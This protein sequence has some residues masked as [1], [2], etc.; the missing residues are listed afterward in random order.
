MGISGSSMLSWDTVLLAIDFATVAFFASIIHTLE[1]RLYVLIPMSLK[2]GLYFFVA[3]VAMATLFQPQDA[4]RS[5]RKSSFVIMIASLFRMGEAV[6]TMYFPFLE[7]DWVII[8]QFPFALLFWILFFTSREYFEDEIARPDTKNFTAPKPSMNREMQPLITQDNRKGEKSIGLTQTEVLC[9]AVQTGAGVVIAGMI[10][11]KDDWW[12]ESIF[13]RPVIWIQLV[14]CASYVIIKIVQMRLLALRGVFFSTVHSDG[15]AWS[16]LLF[17]TLARV[18]LDAYFQIQSNNLKNYFEVSNFINFGKEVVTQIIPHTFHLFNIRQST[19]FSKDSTKS[20]VC[21]AAARSKLCFYLAIT[22][23]HLVAVGYTLELDAS[24]SLVLAAA[25]AAGLLS[26]L[27]LCFVAMGFMAPIFSF[28][29]HLFSF[30]IVRQSSR[31]I[32]FHRNVSY[33]AVVFFLLH[34]VLHVIY[35]STCYDNTKCR[36]N[37]GIPNGLYSFHNTPFLTGV[38]MLG[39]F[40]GALLTGIMAARGKASYLTLAL[41]LPLSC[42]G[43]V[44]LFLHGNDNLLR[45]HDGSVLSLSVF[46]ASIGMILLYFVSVRI[47]TLDLATVEQSDEYILLV[48]KYNDSQYIIPGS[49]FNIYATPPSYISLFHSHS[50]PVFSTSD[51]QIAFLIRKNSD[52]KSFT[53]NLMLGNPKSFRVQGPFKG[54]ARS[55]IHAIT[56]KNFR[57]CIFMVGWQAGFAN[58]FSLLEYF[59]NAKQKRLNVDSINCMFLRINDDTIRTTIHTYIQNLTDD[60]PWDTPLSI[61][62]ATSEDQLQIM[63]NLDNHIR[64]HQNGLSEAKLR[65]F[66]PDNEIWFSVKNDDLPQ[67]EDSES[68]HTESREIL[69]APHQDSHFPASPPSFSFSS[70][71]APS[72]NVLPSPPTAKRNDCTQVEKWI[73]FCGN[74]FPYEKY[75]EPKWYPYVESM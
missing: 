42:A 25:H 67:N 40:I 63:T 5:F 45:R 75:K 44:A 65:E 22:T 1:P 24:H 19:K 52:T 62:E 50:F 73:Y 48:L 17:G 30:G 36:K 13:Y 37:H 68:L 72:P 3:L 12:E 66:F 70:S 14:C 10:C 46:V 34:V 4:T 6:V 69:G 21:D 15:F 57:K 11:W 64:W 38:I 53:S 55:F 29:V 27:D 28:L 9:L 71:L 41:H 59:K 31:K 2:L 39:C 26:S 32:H 7:N 61:I 74:N 33:S 8:T 20:Y 56:S 51:S 49:F 47:R 54:P 16:L 43:F 35:W 58:V 23:L 60:W 18:S